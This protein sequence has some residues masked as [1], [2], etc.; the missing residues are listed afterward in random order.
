MNTKHKTLIATMVLGT[1]TLGMTSTAFAATEDNNIEPAPVKIV[2]TAQALETQLPSEETEERG[3]KDVLKAVKKI[4]V[5]YWD[6][7]PLPDKADSVRD[8]LLS[9]LDY[10]FEF[11]D[12]VETAIRNAIYDVFPDAWP[13]VVDGAVWFIMELLPF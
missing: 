10:Y 13:S 2:K 12:D 6:E 8:A 11:T 4:V 1:F 3:V 7:L 9:A 5:D